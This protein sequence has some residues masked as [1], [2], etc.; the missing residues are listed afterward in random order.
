MILLTAVA[1]SACRDHEPPSLVAP[2]AKPSLQSVQPSQGRSPFGRFRPGEEHSVA[3]ANEVPGFGGFFIDEAGNLHAYLLDVKQAGSARAALARVLAERQRG[4]TET[5]RRLRTR[6]DVVI[7]QGQFTFLQ[8]ADW[9]NQIENF[10][11]A[12]PGVVWVGLDEHVNRVAMG[13]DRTRPATVEAL[14]ARKLTQLGIPREVVSFVSADPI[15]TQTECDPTAVD[16]QDPCTLNPDDPSCQTEDDPCTLDPGACTDPGSLNPEDPS[17]SFSYD[18]SAPAKTLGSP[19]ERMFGGIRIHNAAAGGVCTLGFPVW[20]D[21]QYA[22]VTNSHCT[23]TEEYP[24]IN[25]YFRQPNWNVRPLAVAQEWKDPYKRSSGFRIADASVALMINNFNVYLGYVARPAT[26]A[27]GRY[28]I[29]GD[30]TLASGS[31]PWI[32]IIGEGAVV[33]DQLFDKIGATTGWSYGY[34]RYA[35]VKRGNFECVSWVAASAWDGDSG[36]PVLRYY[37][38]NTALLV[39]MVYAK[40]SGGF[41]MNP[42]SQIRRHLDASGSSAH[43]MY[44]Y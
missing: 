15:T 12:V 39:G 35:C 30:T 16:C 3:L 2:T 29:V 19:F 42:I 24:D 28:A 26:R 43:R 13:V 31:S 32:R 44:T 36:A 20:Y 10:T 37:T 14:V 6:S 23:P 18:A 38:N 17:F 7:H 5:E 21:G 4:Y 41:W 25:S 1:I 34:A 9:R 11:T 22:F 27:F 8:L 40:E 33:K